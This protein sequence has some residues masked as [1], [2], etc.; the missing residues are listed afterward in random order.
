MGHNRLENNHRAALA[1]LRA[2]VGHLRII[3]RQMLDDG[4]QLSGDVGIIYDRAAC[5]YRIVALDDGLIIGP[6]GAVRIVARPGVCVECGRV[7]PCAHSR[8][9]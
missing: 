8:R 6:L 4:A 9:S 7:E 3:T 1:H 5:E 2:N